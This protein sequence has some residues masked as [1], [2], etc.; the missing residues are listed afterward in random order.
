MLPPVVVPA[1]VALPA[2]MT[3]AEV[4]VL[5]TVILPLKVR[6]PEVVLISTVSS[7]VEL[8]ISPVKVKA[9]PAIMV[10]S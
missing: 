3:I 6:L 5:D 4:P 1:A 8:P 10:R 2:L 9:D 7:A